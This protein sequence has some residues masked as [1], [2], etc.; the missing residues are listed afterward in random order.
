MGTVIFS[1][2]LDECDVEG[3]AAELRRR[4]F[5]VL[6]M[7]EKFRRRLLHPLDDF[8]E[9]SITADLPGGSD[10]LGADDWKIVGA[11]MDEVN[12]IVDPY[13]AM[14]DDFGPVTPDHIPFSQVFFELDEDRL[15]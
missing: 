8:L 5:E 14:A 10:D 13:G 15:Q 2:D 11:V 12:A 1:G 9:V 7:P 4:G 3:A 6:H